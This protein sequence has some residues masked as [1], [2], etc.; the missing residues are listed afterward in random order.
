MKVETQKRLDLLRVYIPF[1]ILALIFIIGAVVLWNNCPKEIGRQNAIDGGV[2]VEAEIVTVQREPN[3][4]GSRSAFTVWYR[5]IDANGI[6][7]SGIAESTIIGE[8]TAKSYIGKKINIYIDGKG[9]SIP[10]GHKTNL[11]LA[12]AGA[13]ILTILSVGAVGFDIWLMFFQG[14]KLKKKETEDKKTVTQRNVPNGKR[15]V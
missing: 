6:E 1:I 12:V 4:T 14:N 15:R 5:Y 13:T 7:Y 9:N 2:I 3:H 8:N 10:V 11:G